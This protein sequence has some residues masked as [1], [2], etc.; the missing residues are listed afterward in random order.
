VGKQTEHTSELGLFQAHTLPKVDQTPGNFHI[1]AVEC[2]LPNSHNVF[3]GGTPEAVDVIPL[4]V[5]LLVG[6]DRIKVVRLRVCQRLIEICASRLV[7]VNKFLDLFIGHLGGLFLEVLR[8][9]YCLDKSLLIAV[10]FIIK[11]SSYD[12]S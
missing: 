3:G 10:L 1:L 8:T 9:D 5:L 4:H 12:L 7:Y 11:H 2:A 6:R